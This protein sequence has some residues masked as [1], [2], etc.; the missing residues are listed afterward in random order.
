MSLRNYFLKRSFSLLGFLRC[1]F[2]GQSFPVI[3]IDGC[4][5]FHKLDCA[6][7]I[8][9]HLFSSDMRRAILHTSWLQ[10]FL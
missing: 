6:E 8:L 4:G 1:L 7:Y 3:L 9:W 2:G 10:L 5:L